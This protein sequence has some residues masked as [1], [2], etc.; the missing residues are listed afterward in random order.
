[1]TRPATQ[2]ERMGSLLERLSFQSLE[3]QASEDEKWCRPIDYTGLHVLACSVFCC[4]LASFDVRNALVLA[5]D[6]KQ[7][8]HGDE[9]VL[10]V[11][12]V[13]HQD[14]HHTHVWQVP[15]GREMNPQP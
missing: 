15:V 4:G 14:R 6:D 7:S 11:G 9:G 10:G 5:G 3:I 2:T 13:I 8:Q 1:M 12:V